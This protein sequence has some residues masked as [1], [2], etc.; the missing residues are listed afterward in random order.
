MAKWIAG[1]LMVAATGCVVTLPGGPDPAAAGTVTSPAH[2]ALIDGDTATASLHVAGTTDE[3]TPVDV[4]VL[5]DPSELSSWATIGTATPAAGAFAT[6]VIPGA[7]F[8]VS[9]F[10]ALA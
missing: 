3:T 5:A 10:T 8:I 1:V 6:D 7:G 9:V 2:G 4:Q